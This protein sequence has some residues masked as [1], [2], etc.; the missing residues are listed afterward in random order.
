MDFQRLFYINHEFENRTFDWVRLIF[1]F[2]GS[3]IS[4][5]CR[6]Q[7]NSIHRLSSIEFDLVRLKFSSIGFDLRCRAHKDLA[8]EY[9]FINDFSEA[10][11]SCM[12]AIKGLEN[13]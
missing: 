6:T 1:F 4:F 9:L 5:D 3:S 12:E 7:S 10:E 8:D 2:S 11:K 13:M